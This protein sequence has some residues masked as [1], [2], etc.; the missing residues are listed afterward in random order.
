MSDNIFNEV[1]Q[2][3]KGVEEKLLGPAYPYYKNIKSPSQIGM[4]DDGSL[5]ALAE[6]I[7]G[8]ISYVEVLVTGNSNASTTGGPLG[9][10]FFLKTGAKCKATNTCTDPNDPSTCQDVDRYIYVDNVPAGNIPFISQGL[11]VDF[12]EFKGLI[13]GSM[14]NLNVLNPY[15]IMQAFLS[16]STPACHELTM[17]TISV[18]NV[19]SSETHYVTLTDIQN[20][21]PCTFPNNTNPITKKSCQ[22]AFQNSTPNTTTTTAVLPDDPLAQIYFAGLALIGIY[23]LYRF[24]EKSH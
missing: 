13:P 16:G 11:G 18:D 10:K 12:T 2:D 5:S 14:S 19:S 17:Q 9:N 22:E 23:I 24:M 21:D 3:V 8:L 7:D 4:S 20:M 6:D 15:G 1:L